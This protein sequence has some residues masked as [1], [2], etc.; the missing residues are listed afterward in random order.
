[1]TTLQLTLAIVKPHIIKNP[2]SLEAIRNI[3]VSSNFKVVKS[4]RKNITLDEA[5]RFYE[6]HM[7]KFFYNRLI[8][9]MT[10]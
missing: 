6:E 8:T 9:F 5:E 4:K 3:I 7:H 2:F 1:M 10:R